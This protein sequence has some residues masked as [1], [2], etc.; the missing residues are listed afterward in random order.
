MRSSKQQEKKAK[1]L[2]VIEDPAEFAQVMLNHRLWSKQREIMQSVARH[3]R[4]AVKACHAS[5]KTFTAADAV[6]W[7][8]THQEKA[9]ALTTA[10]TRTQVEDVLWREIRNAVSGARIRYPPPTIDSLHIG[11]TRYA[12]GLSTNEGVRFQGFHGNVLIVVDEAPGVRPEIWEAIEGIRAGGDVRVLALGNPTIASG[13]FH[14]AFTDHR[15]GWNVITISAFDTPNLEGLTLESLLALSEAELQRDVCPYLTTRGWVKEKYLEWGL[16]HP[17][18]QARVMGQFPEQGEGALISLAWLEAGGLREAAAPGDATFDAGVDVADGGE[19]ETVLVVRRGGQMVE[20]RCWAQAD[21]RGEVAAALLKY[22]GRLRTVNVDKV[23]V[24]AYFEKHLHDLGYPTRGVNVGEAARDGERFVNLK[25]ELYWGLRERCEKGDIGGLDGKAVAQLATIRYRLNARGQ[26]VIESKDEMRKRGVK[27]PDHAE[28]IML[29]FAPPG[30]HGL[31]ELWREQYEEGMAHR[32][33]T[34][35][36]D[37]A[38]VRRAELAAAQKAGADQRWSPHRTGKPCAPRQPQSSPVAATRVWLNI[39]MPG[40]AAPAVLVAA[41][42]TP[43]PLSAACTVSLNFHE[44]R[45]S[46]QQR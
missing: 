23:G 35:R 6:L 2:Q 24:G 41:G 29:A 5:G 30:S 16:G 8:I 14:D 40:S 7:W 15:E 46:Q 43:R 37:P 33:Q 1:L 27:S 38:A 18:W 42:R 17:L 11:P 32:A 39:R 31:I 26:V 45:R 44:V 28:A 4:T 13:P 22:K 3:P 25:A 36:A 34:A 19:N 9:I 20:K 21:A 12:K 10:P